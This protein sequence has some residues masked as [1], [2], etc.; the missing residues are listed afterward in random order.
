[1]NPSGRLIATM[2]GVSGIPFTWANLSASQ[3]SDLDPASAALSSSPVL[4]YLRGDRSN[5]NPDG[6]KYRARSTVLGDI[7]HS[8]PVY[9][10]DG[11]NETVF[12]GANDGMLHAINAE[13]GSERFAYIPSML[14]PRLADLKSDPY[15]HKYYVDGR[16]DVRKF[17]STTILV[18]ALGAGGKGLFALDVTDADAADEDDAAS[19]VLWEITNSTTGFANLGHTYGQPVLTTLDSTAVAIVGN[20]YNNTGNGHASLFVINAN[21]GELIAEI[22]TGSGSTTSPNGLSSPTVVDVD[23]DG[24]ADYTYAGDIDGN[25]WKFDLSANSATKL[26]TTDPAQAITMAPGI[27]SHP[28]GGFMVTFATGRMFNDTDE[29]DIATHYA[30]GS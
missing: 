6:L 13:T 28:K 11:T 25:L 17:G 20:G 29:T 4:N 30:Y 27:K 23:G 12:V 22:D 14:I 8:T 7:I 15:V 1:L 5:E 18:G 16:M 21:T 3:K 2:K 26:H 9:W 19:K 24:A 10:N